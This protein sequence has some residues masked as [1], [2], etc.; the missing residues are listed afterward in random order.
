MSR[1]V[2]SLVYSRRVGSA[3]KKAILAYCADRASDDGSGIWASKGTIA[4]V[5]ECGRSTVIRSINEFLEDGILRRTG[6]R[7]H[8][9]GET[10]EYRIDLRRVEALPKIKDEEEEPDLFT[11][12]ETVRKKPAAPVPE[13]DQCHSGT[14]ATAGLVPERD[15]GSA[16]VVGE[17][18]PQR[19]PNRQSTVIQPSLIGHASDFVDGE[20]V[21]VVQVEEP[22]AKRTKRRTRLPEDWQPSGKN[23]A[24]AASKGM[25]TEEIEHESEQFRNHHVGRGSLMA[26]W[27]AAWRTWVGNVRRY[28]GSA[29]NPGRGGPADN[30]LAGFQRSAARHSGGG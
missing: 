25:T 27:D 23:M 30:L 22:K 20:A 11:V 17:P 2:V 1:K 13:R 18:V 9:N 5:C 26:D 6:S 24:H 8:L 3:H 16:T 7:R 19:D 10:T 4:S 21:E 29:R 15:G 14:S 28:S 12:A